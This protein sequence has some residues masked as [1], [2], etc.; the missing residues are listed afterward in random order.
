MGGQGPP[1]P[2]G[3]AHWQ[4]PLAAE[5]WPGLITEMSFDPR[6]EEEEGYRRLGLNSEKGK[7]WG[8]GTPPPPPP[9]WQV[10][11]CSISFLCLPLVVTKGLLGSASQYP[12]L[13][14]CL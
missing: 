9:D 12:A 8:T 3:G 1:F 11:V 2:V 14:G 5:A 6:K 4:R 7:A 13:A 10:W